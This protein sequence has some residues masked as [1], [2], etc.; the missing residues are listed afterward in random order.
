MKKYSVYTLFATVAVVFSLA[1]LS[2][3]G[4]DDPTGKEKNTKIIS[5]GTWVISSVMVDGVDK[6]DLFTG[7][8]LEFNSAGTYS[9]TN[10]EPVWK[11]SGTW[12]FKDNSGQVFLR[13]D[14]KEVTLGTITET[15]LVLNMNWDKTTLGSG[16]SRSVSG[17]H[18]FTFTK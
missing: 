14:G 7:F 12:S 9:S 2:S 6:S 13:D 17:N 16:R 3:C 10:G 11:A 5:S 18:T 8:T 1:L 4:P 15:A